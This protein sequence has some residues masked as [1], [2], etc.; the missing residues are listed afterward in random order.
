MWV[1]KN[2]QY[3]FIENM[4][5]GIFQKRGYEKVINIDEVPKNKNMKIYKDGIYRSVDKKN[6][7]KYIDNG[8]KKGG[9]N[10]PQPSQIGLII[11]DD[12]TISRQDNIHNPN[13]S[14]H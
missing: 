8:W 3:R 12:Y 13:L 11:V 4:R 14:L 6:L 5:F 9:C 1:K 7:K 10:E 2:N